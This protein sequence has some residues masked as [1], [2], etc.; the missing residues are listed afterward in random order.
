MKSKKMG[1]QNKNGCKD[2][3]QYS[4]TKYRMTETRYGDKTGVKEC[5]P[6]L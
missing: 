3:A 4:F 2:S 6:H 1:Y 5:F